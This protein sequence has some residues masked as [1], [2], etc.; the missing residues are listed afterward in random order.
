[1]R[2]IERGDVVQLSHRGMGLT[3][4]AVKQEVLGR[5]GY[6]PQLVS[7]SSGQSVL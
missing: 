2:G 1:M 4:T 3:W 6:V 5:G 7:I